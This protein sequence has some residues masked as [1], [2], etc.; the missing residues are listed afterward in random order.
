MVARSAQQ[1]VLWM[2]AK[3]AEQ[4]VHCW[5]VYLGTMMAEP[6]AVKMGYP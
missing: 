3:T 4:M 2:A 1:L 5:A 6:K